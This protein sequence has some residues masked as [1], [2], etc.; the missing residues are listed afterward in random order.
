ME[1]GTTCMHDWRVFHL[2]AARRPAYYL[3]HGNLRTEQRISQGEWQLDDL[4]QL[5]LNSG[6]CYLRSEDGASNS[7]LL[8]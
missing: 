5:V 3:L 4:S 6:D 2:R 1:S 7:S 8:I